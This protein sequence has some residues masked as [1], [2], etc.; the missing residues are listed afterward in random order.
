MNLA[1]RNVLRYGQFLH[2][3]QIRSNMPSSSASQSNTAQS[4]GGHTLRNSLYA[5]SIA[6]DLVLVGVRARRWKVL[7]FKL[8]ANSI[9]TE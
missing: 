1:V 3:A 6:A 7:P 9:E 2:G 8:Y 4:A 5:N